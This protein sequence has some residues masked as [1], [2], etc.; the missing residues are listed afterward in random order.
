MH[1]ITEF[2][3]RAGTFYIATMD[4]EQPRVRP[5]GAVAEWEG[6]IYLQTSSQ[7]PVFRQIMENPK[8]EISGM[9][10]GK[11]IRLTGTLAQDDRREARKAVLD[12][13][14]ELRKIGYDEDDGKCEVVYFTQAK[15]DI[16]SFTEPMEIYTL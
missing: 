8:V 2:L 3:R 1:K 4:G 7:K 13:C 6:K 14:P 15:A 16:C 10:D 12:A 9:A 11:W 5:F